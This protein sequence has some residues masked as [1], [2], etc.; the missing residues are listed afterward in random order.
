MSQR[1]AIYAR[2]STPQQ[3]REATIESQLAELKGHAR[4]QKYELS[5]A[6]VFVD[7]AISGA[8]LG[9]PG[10]DRLRDEAAERA[11][12]A[13]QADKQREIEKKTKDAAEAEALHRMNNDSVPKTYK[14][15]NLSGKKLQQA[16]THIPGES[17]VKEAKLKRLKRKDLL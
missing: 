3:E 4:E 16:E 1:A 17:T 7:Q 11:R 15:D 10:L 12:R 8:Q 14:D 6:H 9:R 5:E 13:A 2:V